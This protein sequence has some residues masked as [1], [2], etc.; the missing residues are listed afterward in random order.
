MASALDHVLLGD[1]SKLHGVVEALRLVTGKG[2]LKQGIET[3]GAMNE[4]AM[5]LT[6]WWL[7]VSVD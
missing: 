6:T 5:L 7:Q 2:I 3:I 1:L 4:A